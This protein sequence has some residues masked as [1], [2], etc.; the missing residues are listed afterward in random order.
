MKQI[1]IFLSLAIVAASFACAGGENKPANVAA[2]KPSNVVATP[3][4]AATIDE[5]ASG[6][7]V[8]EIN[9]ANCHKANGIG[10]PVEIEGKKLNPDNLTSDKIKGF[11]DEKII[12]YIT[13]GIEDEGMP[14]FKGKLSEGE[15]RDVV[16]YV[17]TEIQKMPAASPKR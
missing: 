6:R 8:Y 15:M 4:P 2:N 5:L 16:K 10:G 13:N 7:K 9:C 3:L 17:R 12:G 14:S 11:S 1:T